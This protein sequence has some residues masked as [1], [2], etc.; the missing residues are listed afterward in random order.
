MSLK[1]R[2]LIQDRVYWCSNKN[3]NYPIIFKFDKWKKFE[4]DC[5]WFDTKEKLSYR[6]ELFHKKGSFSNE[7]YETNIREA[8]IEEIDWLN[9]CIEADKFIPKDQVKPKVNEF[10]K[11]DYVVLLAGCDGT[12]T[13]PDQIPINYCYRLSKDSYEDERG[14]GVYISLSEKRNGWSCTLTRYDNCKLKFRLATKEEIAE[15]NRLAKPFDV[16]TLKPESL[17]GRYIKALV[18]YPNGGAVEKDEIGYVFKYGEKSHIYEVRFPSQ[19]PYAISKVSIID[20]SKY[21]LLPIDYNPNKSEYLEP[22]DLVEGQWYEGF[23]IYKWLFKF[24]S[25]RNN[26]IKTRKC[27]TPHDGYKDLTFGGISP[28]KQI[29]LANLEE[30]YKYF[31]EERPVEKWEPKVGD[32]VVIKECGWGTNI[33]D[34]GLV[35]KI[36]STTVSGEMYNTEIDRNKIG[37]NDR[38]LSIK[39]L[40]K[41]LPHEIPVKKYNGE[42]VHCKTQDEWNFVLSKFNPKNI[43]LREFDDSKGKTNCVVLKST[44]TELIGYCGSRQNWINEGFKITS[45]EGFCKENGYNIIT[46]INSSNGSNTLIDFSSLSSSGGYDA[47]EYYGTNYSNIP[48]V[49]DYVLDKLGESK[50]LPNN[51]HSNLLKNSSKLEIYIDLPTPIKV[52]PIIELKLKQV[53][54]L[55]IK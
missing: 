29:K 44:K 18:N 30:V 28:I 31:P 3:G 47:R 43:L 16:T 41:A 53:N 46:T 8:T 10:K 20:T 34:V 13:W 49:S 50:E 26:D 38:Y 15:Y 11:D 24:E 48:T 45:F 25:L 12:N 14:F 42:V 32:W 22:E 37:N 19:D 23:T 33:K 5:N 27:C 1:V 35:C 51:I 55:T 40:R 4:N 52:E 7:D 6:V 2:D 9:A 36:V 54:K 39:A 17:V 21:E